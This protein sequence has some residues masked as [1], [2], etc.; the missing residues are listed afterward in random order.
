M[1]RSEFTVLR[2]GLPCCSCCSSSVIIRSIAAPQKALPHRT[3]KNEWAAQ[4]KSQHQIHIHFKRVYCQLVMYFFQKFWHCIHV[5]LASSSSQYMYIYRNTQGHPA[6][7]CNTLQHSA[8]H[9]NALQYTAIHDAIHLRT[10]FRCWWRLGVVQCVA[11][12][13]SVVQCVAVCCSVVQCG[14]VWCS[15]VQCGAVCCSVFQCVASGKF[16]VFGV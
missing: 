9:C 7:L 15:V 5:L 16:H 3:C 10:L 13:C 8:T 2:C 11:V 6:T 14:A 1:L 4:H 12:C